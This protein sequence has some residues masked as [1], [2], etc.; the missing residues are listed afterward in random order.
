MTAPDQIAR[1]QT[2]GRIDRSRTLSFAFD[3][4]LYHGHPGDTL[5][6]ALIAN[7]VMLVGRSFKYHRPRGIFTAAPEE[8]NALVELRSGARREPNTKATTIALYDGL[9]A[10]SQNRWPSLAFDVAAVNSAL[11]P[12]FGAGFYY[13]TF[14]WPPAFW[15]KVYEPL[16][17][18]AAGLGH[19]SAEPDPDTYEKSHIF[20]DVLV[21]GAGPAGLMA[22]LTAA[23]AGARVLL[24]EEDFECGGRLL[25]DAHEIDGAPAQ[26]WL[27]RAVA[28]LSA[29]PRV[30]VMTRTSLVAAYDGNSYVAL[31]R[32]NDHLP[33]PPPHQPRQRLWKI[34]ARQA[35]IATGAI[36]R[37]IAF[38][39]ND[40]PGVM[41]ASALRSYVRRFAALPGK[42]ICVFTA[43]DDG[44]RTATELAAA[45]VRVEAVID[46]RPSVEPQLQLA[47]R[48]A[49]AQLFL[50]FEVIATRGGGR[51]AGIS[52]AP[53]DGQPID[54]VCDTLA[55]SGGWN[56][57]LGFISHLGA[58]PQWSEDIGAFI[59][60]E[61]PPG[62]EVAGAAAGQLTLRQALNGGADAGALCAQA[63]GCSGAQS[64]APACGPEFSAQGLFWHAARSRGAAFVDLQNDVTVKDVKQAAAEGFSSAE[65]LKRYT[66]LGM[67]TDQGK[68]SSVIAH[69]ILAA[70]L[71]H[72]MNEISAPQPRPPHVPVAIGALAGAH[73]GKHFRPARLTSTHRWAEGFG[74]AFVEAGAWM[75]AQWY[76]QAGEADWL[77]TVS[78]EVTTVRNAVGVCDVSTLGKIDIQGADAG[79]FLDRV[80]INTFST[81]GVGKARY[82]VMLRE[83]GFVMD[84][85]TTS[86]L[87]PDHYFMTT[88]TANAARVMQHLEF[89]HQVLWPALDVQMIS[90]TEQWA[91][92]A[93]AGSKARDVL[94]RVVDPGFDLSNAGFPFLA[95]APV[96]VGGVAGRLFRISFSG[97]LAYELSVPARFGEAVMRAI[98]GA[99]APF[100]IAPYGTEALGV[101]RIEKG[102]AAG[103][104]LNGQ[105]TARDLGLGRMM[106]SKKDYIGRV[107]AGRPAL[108]DPARPALIGFKPVDRTQRL[109]GGA[110][111]IPMNLAPSPESDEGHMTS[112]AFSPTLGHWIGLGLLRRG[113]QRIGERVRAY[114]P[115][116]GNDIPV[117]V[118]APVF[119]DPEGS[120]LHA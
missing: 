42:A 88:T 2:G 116:R 120:R 91:Q 109:Y 11:A 110:H 9:I 7:G 44:W 38:G 85:G 61:L 69:G 24:C 56:P 99:G 95:A 35:I 37:P 54:L 8:P 90:V 41:L 71:G 97:E 10:R 29:S 104:E 23:H 60:A 72:G 26:G 52:I 118:C 96:T 43:T 82:G 25:S 80:Y 12:F 74:A 33:A 100:G 58:R 62:L 22:A 101:L 114:D 108:I 106:S 84:D 15:E 27:A 117:E 76:A 45:G 40:R 70:T 92:F 119:V 28:E 20:C 53:A 19:A 47:A 79:T 78:R 68:T 3:G 59:P 112:V 49:G 6:S 30:T 66:T 13:K 36:E 1:L 86:R 5:A 18:R 105:T 98:L 89:C 65:H 57:A 93:V 51:L 46:P 67:A 107:L 64:P 39:G 103:N 14:M 75:R 34:V 113:P 4:R 31:E 111:F 48:Q 102:H 50:G 55:V 21:A 77:T 115:V 81:L 63:A 94:A 32:V 87:A 73:R 16:I 83:D 17:R